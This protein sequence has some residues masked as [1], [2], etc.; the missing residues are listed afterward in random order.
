MMI[1]WR[2][3]TL[4][5]ANYEDVAGTSADYGNETVAGKLG[6]QG[7]VEQFRELLRRNPSVP[8]ASEYGPADIAFAVR[9]PLRFQQVWG[10]EKTREWWMEH[11]R[12]VSAYLFGPLQFAWIPVIR[13][14][15]EL[16]RHVVVACSDALGGMGQCAGSER[17]LQATAGMTAHMR[18]RAQ[19]FARQQ[20]EPC[21]EPTRGGPELACMYRDSQGGVYKYLAGKNL[22]ELLG[23]DG[24]PLYQRVTGLWDVKSP[25]ALPGWPAAVDGRIFGLNPDA[26]YALRPGPAQ[27]AKL[28]VAELSENTKIVRYESTA[29]RAILCL[30]P[31]DQRAPRR[32]RVTLATQT[33][34]AQTLLNDR[35]VRSPH[36]RASYEI[37][38]PAHFVF[39]ESQLSAAKTFQ[40][41][42]DGQ[43]QGRY[44]SVATGLE[45]GG[46]YAI[47][48][49]GGLP[50]PGLKRAPT[51]YFLNGGSECEVTLDYVARVPPQAAL[52]VYV[53]NRQKRYGNG[54]IAR[55]YL[56]GRPVH[57]WD[58]CPKPG[59]FDTDVHLWHI[60]L[61]PLSGQ[62]L[63]VTI[64]S[65]A[66]NENNADE[67]WWT[68]PALVADPGQKERFV[69]VTE[70]GEVSE[71]EG[72]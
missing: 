21:F 48:H 66:K 30:A 49:R 32:G 28:Q 29:D 23:P 50:I 45:R 22:Q 39:L 5:D 26:R 44:I 2:Q 47:P 41:L 31:V 15:S 43:E 20:L 3:E 69:R 16:S 11:M 53:R 70:Q 34:F 61:G 55:L 59:A 63:A 38:L 7:G 19:L 36:P 60:P 65:D 13:A 40:T 64:A 67:L 42:G 9:W 46:R 72:R 8:M 37:D 6:A 51:S 1:R 57:Q 56:N 12:P 18:D 10:N 54:A 17:E 25:L 24:R 71:S 14:E 27:P 35:P 33:R 62:P 4:T 52:E 58:F 68:A